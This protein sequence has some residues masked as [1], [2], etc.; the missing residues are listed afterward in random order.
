MSRLTAR[1][2]P[3]LMPFSGYW[4]IDGKP[5]TS[6]EKLENPFQQ[7]KWVEIDHSECCYGEHR[8]PKEK[9]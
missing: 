6:R 4:E 3:C 7:A 5:V 1:E 8:H 2:G 9:G